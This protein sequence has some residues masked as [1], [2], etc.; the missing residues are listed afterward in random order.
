MP[1]CVYL[2]CVFLYFNRRGIEWIMATNSWIDVLNYCLAPNSTVYVVKESCD[3]MYNLLESK[4][5][6]DE[7]FCNVV[8]KRIMQPLLVSVSEKQTFERIL[9]YLTKYIWLISSSSSDVRRYYFYLMMKAGNTEGID[10]W[11]AT[12]LWRHQPMP[13]SSRSTASVNY[14]N[15]AIIDFT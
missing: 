4:V 3:F 7:A 10:C 15:T 14:V 5:H 6:Y 2:E 1:C 12:S 11:L 9:L 8:V 13:N